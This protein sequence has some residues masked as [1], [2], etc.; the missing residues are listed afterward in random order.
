MDNIIKF[1]ESKIIRFGQE[2]ISAESVEDKVN[3]LKEHHI[4]ET[5]SVVMPLL[6][7]S[8]DSAGFTFDPERVDETIKDG[9]LVLESLRSIMCKYYGIPHPFQLISENLFIEDPQMGENAYKLA[10]EINIK[11][12]QVEE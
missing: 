5:L 10:D 6:F 9:A 4:N 2:P 3:I 8:L 11:I 12:K 7:S 1:P